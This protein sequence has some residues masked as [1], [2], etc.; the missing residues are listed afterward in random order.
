MNL[1]RIKHTLLRLSLEEKVISLGAIV[2]MVGCFLPWYTSNVIDKTLTEYGLSGDLGVVGFVIFLMSLLGLLALV[3]ENM[4]LPFPKFGHKRE[5]IVFFFMGQAAFL[6]LLTMAI[7][8]KRSLDFTDADLRFGIYMVLTAAFLSALAAFSLIRKTRPK[9]QM[10]FF[11]PEESNETEGI[12]ENSEE[13]ETEGEITEASMNFQEDK[14][15]MDEIDQ[16]FE[17]KET[18]SRLAS[19]EKEE[20]DPSPIKKT[21]ETISIEPSEKSEE[22]IPNQANYFTKEAGVGKKEEDKEVNK[23]DKGLPTNF[24]QDK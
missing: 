7:Y 2:N 19:T 22:V 15:L 6:T 10:E 16:A 12:L 1:R 4:H 8:T 24:Y 23:S 5:S 20:S 11:E 13:N 9:L 14:E 3:S 21:Q 18:G 17:E